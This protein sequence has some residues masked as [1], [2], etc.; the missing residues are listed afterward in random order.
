[1]LGVL[2]ENHEDS[3]VIENDEK[4]ELDII[5]PGGKSDYDLKKYDSESLIDITSVI[6]SDGNDII[7][8]EHEEDDKEYYVRITQESCLKLIHKTFDSM[9]VIGAF[10]ILCLWISYNRFNFFPFKINKLNN[11]WYQLGQLTFIMSYWTTNIL[12]LRILL[13][14]GYLFFVISTTVLGGIPSMDFYLFTYIYFIINLKKIMELMYSKR[15]IV[16]DEYREQIYEHVFEGIMTKSEFEE[17]SKTAL[18]RELPKGGFYCKIRDRCNNLSILVK[19]R[20]R[21]F[22]NSENIKTTFIEEN[23]FIDSAEWLLKHSKKNKIKQDK[24]RRFNYYMKADDKCIYLTWPREILFEILKENEDLQTKLKGALG[25]DVS[26]KLF[27]NSSL[28]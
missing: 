14:V 10:L 24:G 4:S 22:K 7:H 25:L 5:D 20:L 15:P 19:G 3:V 23:E 26:H 9:L 18:I 8:T 16:F 11:W 13:I 17:L 6:S 27:N 2:D 28:Y 1:M 12:L 21:I